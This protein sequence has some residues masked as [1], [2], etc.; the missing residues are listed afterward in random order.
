MG[1]ELVAGQSCDTM[2][3]REYR[4]LG[5]FT[6][7]ATRNY[8]YA[9]NYGLKA[10]IGFPGRLS[11]PGFMKK[12]GWNNIA[13]MK[14]YYLRAGVK[15][16]LGGFID[17]VYKYILLANLRIKNIIFNYKSQKYHKIMKIDQIPD[18]I[19]ELLKDY[20]EHE[21][22]S[23]W[24]DESYLKWRYKAHPLN[25]Y[26]YFISTIGDQIKTLIICREMV[27][28]V[29]ICE[30]IHKD[31][32]ILENTIVLQTLVRYYIEKG[33]QNIQ[34]YGHDR[35]FFENVFSRAGFKSELASEFIFCG[36]TFTKDKFSE[37][38]CMASNWTISYGDA[39]TI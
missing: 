6:D 14:S 32:N 9:E 28:D 2:V 20:R 30:F 5:I 12:L 21:V 10:V 16:Q 3:D 23:I 15:R 11:Y 36:R 13:T 27:H 1:Y 33:Y 34:Y 22:L 24:K 35:G 18:G 38:F 26:S 19:D 8:E 29:A 31:G 17:I 4:K 7:L 25:Q 39:D 37:K